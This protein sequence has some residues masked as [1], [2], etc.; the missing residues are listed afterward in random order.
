MIYLLSKSFIRRTIFQFFIS[1][2]QSYILSFLHSWVAALSFTRFCHFFHS[3]ILTRMTIGLSTPLIQTDL[4]HFGGIFQSS[5]LFKC[6]PNGQFT[7]FCDTF[8]DEMDEGNQRDPGAWLFPPHDS[9]TP[10][11]P[12]SPPTSTPPPSSFLPHPS[13]LHHFLLEITSMDKR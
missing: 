11:H 7:H 12:P 9:C 10:L 1:F 8:S 6:I 13:Q 4:L 2:F 3:G 5:S